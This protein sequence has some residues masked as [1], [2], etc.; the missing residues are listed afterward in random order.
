M[1]RAKC[2]E[3]CLLDQFRI[4]RAC[5]EKLINH[6]E[7]ILR[8]SLIRRAILP[9]VLQTSTV[10]CRVTRC[11]YCPVFSQYHL[12]TLQLPVILSF[13]GFQTKFVAINAAILRVKG[14]FRKI[15]CKYCWTQTLNTITIKKIS[16]CSILRLLVP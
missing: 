9:T 1:G 4:K 2:E 5:I 16:G 8:C 7:I 12:L 13:E 15:A 6:G 10:S 3:G 11:Y 14:G